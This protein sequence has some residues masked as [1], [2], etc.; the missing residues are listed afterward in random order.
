MT[1]LHP[2]GVASSRVIPNR[3][4]Q[5]EPTSWI[6]AHLRQLGAFLYVITVVP[7]F[8]FLYLVRGFLG[9]FE[10]KIGN[11]RGYHPECPLG[12]PDAHDAGDLCPK[13]MVGDCDLCAATVDLDYYGNCSRAGPRW[14]F[15]HISNRRSKPPRVR[16]IRR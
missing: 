14:R 10:A 13:A 12:C 5:L 9:P 7:F 11:R 15:H 8:A 2:A 3:V 1:T 6:R 4:L 16:Q